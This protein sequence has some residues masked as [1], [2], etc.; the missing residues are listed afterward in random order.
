MCSGY[1]YSFYFKFP[2]F[3]LL[4]WKMT[5]ST[6]PW[7]LTGFSCGCLW[8]CVCWELWDSSFIPSSVSLNEPRLYVLTFSLIFCLLLS[9]CSTL[10]TSRIIPFA[11]V[12]CL[13]Q[14]PLT[15]FSSFL[16][17]LYLPHA[18]R[19][20]CHHQPSLLALRCLFSHTTYPDF[21]ILLMLFN[22][23]LMLSG[24]TLT[25]SFSLS[26]FLKPCS[27]FIISFFLFHRCLSFH[28]NPVSCWGCIST[29]LCV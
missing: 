24:L 27:S 8:Q 14:M 28:G 15:S 9:L 29:T 7:S 11:G 23:Q 4:R 5:G 19:W 20:D 3:S 17:L 13:S 12:S 25:A 18:L 2:L 10:S 16:F 1:F 22:V 21:L 6:L 26:L